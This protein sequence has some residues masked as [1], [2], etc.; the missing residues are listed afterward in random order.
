[1]DAVFSPSWQ[2]HLF[3]FPL[4]CNAQKRQLQ[5]DYPGTH[6]LY[7]LLP[8]PLSL[9]LSPLLSAHFP[10]HLATHYVIDLTVIMRANNSRCNTTCPVCA[11]NPSANSALSPTSSKGDSEGEGKGGSPGKNYSNGQQ[12]ISSASL[13]TQ[14]Q[15][16]RATLA[17]PFVF[18]FTAQIHAAAVAVAVADA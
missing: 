15:P 18:R 2:T 12:L 11:A 5:R 7:L 3:Q 16:P 9:S 4:P 13:A 17:N 8:S 14:L 10:L 1:M 6:W